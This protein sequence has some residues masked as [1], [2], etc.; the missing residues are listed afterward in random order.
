[1]SKGLQNACKNKKNTLYREFIKH[2]SKEAENKYKKN[3]NKLINIMRNI[4]GI[5]NILNSIN[6]A[7]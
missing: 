6:Q 7:E 3:K 1:M 5:W 2:R 4:K